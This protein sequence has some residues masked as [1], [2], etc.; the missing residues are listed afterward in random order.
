MHRAYPLIETGWSP[1]THLP[2]FAEHTPQRQPPADPNAAP[3]NSSAQEALAEYF[4][5]YISRFS[6]PV[7][8]DAGLPYADALTCCSLTLLL[9]IGGLRGFYPR[10]SWLEPL[11][12]PGASLRGLPYILPALSH[13]AALAACWLLGAL[14]AGAYE[15][16]AFNG[17]WQ[18]ALGRTLRAGAFA[19][20]VLLLS[21]Q[22]VTALNLEAAGID[23][24]TPSLAL[25][26][27]LNQ[28]AGEVAS[29][30]FVQALGLTGFRMFRWWMAQQDWE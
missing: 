20:G 4:G 13:G 15:P 16:E 24:Y 6:S 19:T 14:A 22:F 8:A 18:E 25:D 29:D 12:N 3:G 9:A 21:T 7:V 17:R 27:V 11:G 2:L 10:P 26:M 23:Q 1:H 30:V 5:K 28:V